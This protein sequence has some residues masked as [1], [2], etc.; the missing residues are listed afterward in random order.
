MCE[1]CSKLA[2]KTPEKHQS[3]FI[4]PVFQIMPEKVNVSQYSAATGA[5]SLE[6]LT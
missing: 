6:S 1:I 2:K 4:S 3:P 5:K